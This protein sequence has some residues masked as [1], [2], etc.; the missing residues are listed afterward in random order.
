MI[1]SAELCLACEGVVSVEIG[2]IV[3]VVI[4]DPGLKTLHWVR[5]HL[6]TVCLAGHH[7]SLEHLSCSLQSGAAGTTK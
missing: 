1:C 3:A 7:P 6:G 5:E 4:T 2:Q